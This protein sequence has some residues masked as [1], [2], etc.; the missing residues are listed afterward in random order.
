VKKDL[1]DYRDSHTEYEAKE[2][3]EQWRKEAKAR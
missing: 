3:I 1:R 2:L